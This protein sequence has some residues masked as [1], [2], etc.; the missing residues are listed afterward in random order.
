MKNG[1]KK[2]QVASV[3][4]F[5]ANMV[6][7]CTKIFVGA[8][9][10]VLSITSDGFNNL[11]DCGMNVVSFLT[12][13]FSQKPP[14]KNHPFGYERAEYVT[15]LIMSIV[16]LLVA[17][18]VIKSAF[19]KIFSPRTLDIGATA[20]VVEVVS[21]VAKMGL[22][23]YYKHIYKIT[24]SEILRANATDSLSDSIST[25]GIVVALVLGEAFGVNLDGYIGALVGVVIGVC[26][27]K[28]LIAVSS[29]IIGQG[30]DKEIRTR[31]EKY[32][33]ENGDVL[34]VHD[35]VVFSYGSR[36]FASIHIEIDERLGV[37]SSHKIVDKIERGVGE[38][39][40]VTLTAHHDP[41]AICDKETNVLREI[42]TRL[43]KMENQT[44]S[45]HDFR[46][47]KVDD[48]TIISFDLVIPYGERVDEKTV[49]NFLSKK[50]EGL[51][52]NYK[53]IIKIDRV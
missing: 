38:R 31:I 24:K 22:F 30:A 49:I 50:I 34:G 2:S 16:I 32:I 19:K 1:I 36:I 12:L 33:L 5:V 37:Q 43:V 26:G 48:K 18:E 10:G 51:G 44:H 41:V 4:G 28:N 11:S 27:L 17:F 52:K 29:K 40:G 20:F 25:M 14:D 15:S 13:S 47:F 8:M 21:I 35:L 39:F 53:S 9:S 7:A 42:V 46:L 45:L 3:V 6:L 23:F